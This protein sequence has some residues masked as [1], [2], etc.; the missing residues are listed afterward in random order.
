MSTP[1]E[2]GTR[3]DGQGQGATT[4]HFCGLSNLFQIV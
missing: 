3:K 4:P 1:A 2:A